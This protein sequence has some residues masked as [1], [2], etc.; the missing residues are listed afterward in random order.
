L[1]ISDRFGSN[2][3]L[4][5]VEVLENLGAPRSLNIT[6]SGC[7]DDI[8]IA[9][10]QATKPPV[11]DWYE[12]LNCSTLETAYSEQY[13]EN[14][15]ALDERVTSDGA[16]YTITDVLNTEPAGELIPITTTG[17][18][19]C[20]TPTFDWYALYKC[21][22]GSTANSQAYAI[23]TFSVNDRVESGGSTYTITSVLG[24]SPGGTLISITD[25]GLTGCPTLTTYYELSECSPGVGIA[26][27][28][29]V[30]V[31]V[32]RRYVLPS[33]TPVFYTYTGATLTQSTPP[34]AYNGSIQITPFYSC[35]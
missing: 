20:P 8:T 23:G 9:V 2:N 34:P 12:L 5:Y 22:D 26:Y 1:T 7:E 19:G 24:S 13:D 25:T 6:V 17:E 16:T 3:Q 14:E 27:T 33:M 11:F 30:P 31:S 15:F 10:T 35:P 32:G 29:I 18:E 4:I 28:T 21:S